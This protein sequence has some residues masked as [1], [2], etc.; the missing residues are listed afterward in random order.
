M[1]PVPPVT[2]ISLCSPSHNIAFDQNWRH[3]QLSSAGEKNL[4]NDLEM[5]I[6]VHVQA[7]IP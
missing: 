6:S 2:N 1:T 4:Y 5:L 3:L 7:K